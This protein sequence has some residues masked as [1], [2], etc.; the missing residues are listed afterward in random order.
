MA[1]K[2]K[3]ADI[4]ASKTQ[5]KIIK[6]FV[7]NSR[8]E[9]YQTELCVKLKESLGSIQY[10]LERLVRVGF[11]NLKRTKTRTYY[12]LS[13]KFTLL[14]EFETILRKVKS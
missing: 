2:I 12:S 8:Q 5:A 1:N 14:K 13:S 4:F 6:F 11:L 10:E 9:Y 7:E 3:L